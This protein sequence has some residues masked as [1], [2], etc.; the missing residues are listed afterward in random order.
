[1]LNL[2]YGWRKMIAR[3]VRAVRHIPEDKAARLKWLKHRAKVIHARRHPDA[4]EYAGYHM[5][6]M[7]TKGAGDM[8]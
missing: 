5:A 2:S 4:A 7:L 1:M 8:A 3:D 6:T